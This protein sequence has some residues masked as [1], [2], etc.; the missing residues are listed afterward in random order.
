[1]INTVGEG[2]KHKGKNALCNIEMSESLVIRCAR[3][4]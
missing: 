4:N 1:M 3:V 2:D